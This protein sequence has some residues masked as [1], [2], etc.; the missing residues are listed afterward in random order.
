MTLQRWEAAEQ[1]LREALT[2]A[3]QKPR[4]TRLENKEAKDAFKNITT[5]SA[6]SAAQN[7]A[8]VLKT[9]ATLSSPTNESLLEEA[10]KLYEQTA[11]LHDAHPNAVA[12]K[13]SLAELYTVIGDEDTANELRREIMNSYKR[14]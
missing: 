2:I 10:K 5:L 12:T 4:G 3:T 9:R 14:Q 6:A 11:L 8:V 1:Y 7:L 13:Y